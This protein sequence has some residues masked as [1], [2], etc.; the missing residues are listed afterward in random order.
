MSG[1]SSCSDLK[2]DLLAALRK[3]IRQHHKYARDFLVAAEA[4]GKDAPDLA[5]VHKRPDPNEHWLQRHAYAP[6][7]QCGSGS[8]E[9]AA[10]VV[11]SASTLPTYVYPR[12]TCR[13]VTAACTAARAQR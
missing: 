10:L 2:P 8:D 3:E 4:A 12:A 9:I 5:I 11:G 1:H 13:G 7:Q 6:P